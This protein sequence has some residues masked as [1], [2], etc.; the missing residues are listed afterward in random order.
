M[1]YHKKTEFELTDKGEPFKKFTERI[2]QKNSIAWH[3]YK[4]GADYNLLTTTYGIY[5]DNYLNVSK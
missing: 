5:S 4:K 3:S 1:K 2:K